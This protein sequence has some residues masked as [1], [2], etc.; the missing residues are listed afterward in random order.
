MLSSIKTAI[1][2]EKP[3]LFRDAKVERKAAQKSKSCHLWG[4][5]LVDDLVQSL[6]K[7]CLSPSL[8]LFSQNGINSQLTQF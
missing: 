7:V 6:A 5:V 2:L 8:K 3:F 1:D 4:S